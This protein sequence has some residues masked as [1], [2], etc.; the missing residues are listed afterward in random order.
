MLVE[1][2]QNVSNDCVKEHVKPEGPPVVRNG[3]TPR[4]A[5]IEIE[6]SV[7]CSRLPSEWEAGCG[8]VG[9]GIVREGVST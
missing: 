1:G 8:P 3:G 2:K 4:V 9:K 7:A 6:N 5:T